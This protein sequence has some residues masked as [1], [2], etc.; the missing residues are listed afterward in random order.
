[1]LQRPQHGLGPGAN[2][3]VAIHAVRAGLRRADAH[4]QRLSD[5]CVGFYLV[6]ELP[7]TKVASTMG[8][9][10][11]AATVSPRVMTVNCRKNLGV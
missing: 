4:E 2:V 5:V 8:F 6:K 11:I 10:G 3:N 7:H 9:E 1:M